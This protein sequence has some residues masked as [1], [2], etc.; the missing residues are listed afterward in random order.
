VTLLEGIK[1]N[2]IKPRECQLGCCH[3]YV[4]LEDSGLWTSLL[5]V[6]SLSF[7]ENVPETV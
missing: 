3:G 4:M 1:H 5:A 2:R 6:G 7:P